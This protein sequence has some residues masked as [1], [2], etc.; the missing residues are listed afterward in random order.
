MLTFIGWWL[1]SKRYSDR[2]SIP[3]TESPETVDGAVQ[4]RYESIEKKREAGRTGFDMDKYTEVIEVDTRVDIMP[5]DMVYTTRWLKVSHVDVFIPENKK[6]VVRMWPN[7]RTH[8]ERKRA[9]L[10]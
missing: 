9:Y 7:R 4:I 3:R 8:V 2:E 6:A 5:K 1:Q 10:I